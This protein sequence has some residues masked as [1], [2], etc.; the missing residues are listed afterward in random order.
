MTSTWSAITELPKN[1]SLASSLCSTSEQ[2]NAN[3]S[4]LLNANIAIGQSSVS[5]WLC[6]PDH[7]PAPPH[8]T[9]TTGC[10]DSIAFEELKAFLTHV[11]NVTWKHIH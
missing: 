11:G 1:D 4:F 6:P 10:K 7:T 8:H 5:I 2:L 9:P 3:K